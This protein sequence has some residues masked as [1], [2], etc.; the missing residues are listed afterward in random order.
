MAKDYK[1]GVHG[2]NLKIEI[3]ERIHPGQVGDLYPKHIKGYKNQIWRVFCINEWHFTVIN[4][5]GVKHNLGYYKYPEYV[6]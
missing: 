5:M 2:V 1:W 4:N 3:L 6:V